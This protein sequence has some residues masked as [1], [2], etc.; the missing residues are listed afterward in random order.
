MNEQELRS[1]W[2][3]WCCGGPANAAPA[4]ATLESAAA[5]FGGCL[6]D[7]TGETYLRRQYLV[8]TH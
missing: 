6:D 4:K 1:W 7:I 5:A 8:K 3:A 2:S